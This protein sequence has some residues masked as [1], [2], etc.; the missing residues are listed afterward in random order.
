MGRVLDFDLLVCK[1]FYFF[2]YAAFGSLFP[3][4]AIYFKQQGMNATQ[5]GVLIGIRPFIEFAS[6]PFWASFAD[7]SPSSS[8]VPY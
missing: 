6:A 7:R 5:A 2:F 3:L 8:V 1:A 4:I